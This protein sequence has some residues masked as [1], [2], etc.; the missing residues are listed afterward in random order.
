MTL[1]G[2]DVSNHQ[3]NFDFAAA[4]REGFSFATHKISEGSGYR[5]SYWPRARGEMER[6]FPGRWGGYVYCR[7]NTDPASEARVLREHAGSA[8]FPLQVDYEDTVN[9]GSVDDLLRRIDAYRAVGFERFLPVYLPRWFW[10]SRMGRAPLD[11]LPMGIWNSDYVSGSDYASRLYPGDDWAPLRGSGGG[12]GGWADMGGRPVEIL[13]F[14]ESG[15]V[16]GQLIDVNAFRGNDRKLAALFGDEY[17]EERFDMADEAAAIA[18]QL[19]GP[20]GRGLEILGRAVE[21]DPSRNRFLAE[22]VSV[23]LAQLGGGPNFEGWEQLGDGPTSDVP[24]RTLV[25]GIA[26]IKR[27]NEEILELLRRSSED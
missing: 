13:Q 16:A 27:Q 11:R 2:I 10:E 4:R 18:G 15:V 9:G 7:T 3:G 5:D 26:H 1:F 21:T 14:S 19:F 12:R 17:P 20:E 8:D 6:H 23:I 25:D 24:T 22:A